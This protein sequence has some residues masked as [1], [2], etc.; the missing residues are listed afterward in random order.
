MDEDYVCSDV[1][2]ADAA[3][4]GTGLFVGLV[5]GAAV[6]AGGMLIGILIDGLL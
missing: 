4:L 5:I 6:A 2:D 1:D 3:L